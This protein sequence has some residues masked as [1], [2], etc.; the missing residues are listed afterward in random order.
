MQ[1]EKLKD[2]VSNFTDFDSIARTKFKM[3]ELYHEKQ[4]KY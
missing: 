3:A 1:Q 4:Q 2:F